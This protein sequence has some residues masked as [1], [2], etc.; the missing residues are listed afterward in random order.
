MGMSRGFRRM[1]LVIAILGIATLS[2]LWLMHGE[3]EPL[4]AMPVILAIGPAI[5]VLLIGWVVIGF[6]NSN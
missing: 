6:R 2:L 4:T 5:V 1:I 3:Q